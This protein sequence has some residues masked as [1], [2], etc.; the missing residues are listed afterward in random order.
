MCLKQPKMAPKTT[1]STDKVPATTPQAG[2]SLPL[3]PVLVTTVTSMC[4]RSPAPGGGGCPFGLGDL[5]PLQSTK[6]QN[7]KRELINYELYSPVYGNA[8]LHPRC[9]ILFYTISQN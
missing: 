9:I 5:A 1:A 2:D 8:I 3:P 7:K 4:G 6:S